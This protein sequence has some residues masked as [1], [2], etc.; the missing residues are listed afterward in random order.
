MCT[1]SGE[2]VSLVRGKPFGGR[3]RYLEKEEGGRFPRSRGAI[4]RVV[5]WKSGM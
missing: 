5:H 1:N 2:V 3:M 4:G